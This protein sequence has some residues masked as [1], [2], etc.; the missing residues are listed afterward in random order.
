M[1]PF[2]VNAKQR[3]LVN[4][5]QKDILQNRELQIHY[6]CGHSLVIKANGKSVPRNHIWL[7]CPACFCSPN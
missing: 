4:E 7:A 5:M 1:L 3:Q 6:E 2:P